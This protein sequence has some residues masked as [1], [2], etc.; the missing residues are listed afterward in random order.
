[1]VTLQDVNLGSVYTVEVEPIEDERYFYKRIIDSLS[2]IECENIK[3]NEIF[4]TI[5]TQTQEGV[6]NFITNIEDF[7]ENEKIYLTEEWI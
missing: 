3:K 2:R 5:S 1:M 7:S 6:L 4:L